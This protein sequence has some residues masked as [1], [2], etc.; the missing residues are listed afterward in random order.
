MSKQIQP[1][2]RPPLKSSIRS[3]SVNKL[4]GIFAAVGYNTKMVKYYGPELVTNG[5]FSA[6]GGW[7]LGVGWVIGGGVLNVNALAGTFSQQPLPGIIDGR[8]YRVSI[9]ILN[10]LGGN[11]RVFVAGEILDFGPDGNYN[12]EGVH[13]GAD[14]S[15]YVQVYIDS[16]L[17]IDD[18]SVREITYI[19]K[20]E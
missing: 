10:N 13:V 8:R 9:K 15:V 2:I 4:I 3:I 7:A 6:G 16:N 20:D 18:V 11:G 19:E 14:S 5:D 17:Q 12:L 1:N